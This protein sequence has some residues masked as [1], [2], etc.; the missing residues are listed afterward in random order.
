MKGGLND[1]K[2]Y[3]VHLLYHMLHC[4]K[5]GYHLRFYTAYCNLLRA[6][7][8]VEDC[9]W[10]LADAWVNWKLSVERRP[11]FLSVTHDFSHGLVK[12]R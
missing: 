3:F 5:L 1:K 10:N 4:N 12:A 8:L 7:V 9:H 11:D 2:S 6:R